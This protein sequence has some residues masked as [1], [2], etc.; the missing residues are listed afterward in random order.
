MAEN[1]NNSSA[2]GNPVAEKGQPQGRPC[3]KDCRRCPMPQQ[4]CCAAMLSFQAFD[5][6]NGIIQRLNAQAQCLAD[7]EAKLEAIQSSE[8][9][10]S[11]PCVLSGDE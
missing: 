2:S 4:I 6:M 8:A 7:F 10:L 3:P 11:A 1:K 5:V 9:D